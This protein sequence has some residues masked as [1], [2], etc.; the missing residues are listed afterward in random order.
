MLLLELARSAFRSL[1][2][3]RLRTVLTMLGVIIG[4]G[5]VVGMIS[6][7]EG[8]RA[9][10]ESSIRSLGSN[11]LFVRAALPRSA[12]GAARQGIVTTMKLDDV[13]PIQ[14]VRGVGHVVPESSAATQA[15]YFTKNIFATI[16]G[17]VPEW[18]IVR[19][20][21]MEAGE[22]FTAS[23]VTARRRVAV[24]GSNIAKE[25][26]GGLDPIGE[27]IQLKG[28]SFRVVGVLAEKTESGWF[29]T[30][31][32]IAIPITTHHSSV[33]GVDYLSGMYVQLEDSEAG[34]RVEK[35]IERVLR[36]RHRIQPGEEDDF[37]VTSQSEMLRVME[38]VT[39]VFTALLGGVAAVS[40]LVGG[41]G[42]MNIMLVSVRERTKEIG[43]RKAV[44]A[45]RRDI[46]LQFLFES[47]VVS[48]AGGV[49]G[50]AL[51]FA[52]AELMS[53]VGGWDT[54]VP[55]YAIALAF[56]T[57]AGIGI[58]FG[59]WPAR[60]AALLDPVAALRYE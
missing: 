39:G 22:F 33:F 9:S 41:I 38:E 20:F 35:D 54:I 46:L 55:L 42:I 58:V 5:A 24:L 19:A 18:K 29:G 21:D 4:V 48:L 28:L 16:I 59:V 32:Q 37:D 56:L 15:K 50:I 44:G 8:A 30:N 49:V 52:I 1:A 17:T 57:S 26:F 40:L 47:L 27:R 14:D 12:S 23:D 53:Q 3:N 31:D 36:A 51:G 34:D 11:L 60:Q 2:S 7:G 6:L 25:L 10:V 43:I 13:P 45:R